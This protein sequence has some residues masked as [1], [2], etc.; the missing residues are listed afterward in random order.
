MK[1]DNVENLDWI[2]EQQQ[3]RPLTKKMMIFE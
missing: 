2:L 1:Y 3:K